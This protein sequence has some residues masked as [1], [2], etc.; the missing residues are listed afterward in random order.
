M[1]MTS[2]GSSGGFCAFNACWYRNDYFRRAYLASPTF[3]ALAGA[4]EFL[5]YAARCEPRPIRVY[6]TFDEFEPVVFSG[7]N[8]EVGLAAIRFLTSSGY[9]FRWQYYPGKGHTWGINDYDTQLNALGFIWKNWVTKPVAVLDYS[10]TLNAVIDKNSPWQ[11]VADQTLLPPR[12]AASVDRGTH[13]ARGGEIWLVPKSA[14][15]PKVAEGF[16]DISALTISSDLWRLYIA[17]KRQRYVLSMS[18][19]PDGS[20][21]DLRR[22]NVL[23]LAT[24]STVM[25]ARDMALDTRDRIYAATDAGIQV[26][27]PDTYVQMI[28]PLPGDLPADKVVFEGQTLYVTSGSRIFKR[29]LKVTGRTAGSP[30]SPPLVALELKMIT[31]PFLTGTNRQ[32]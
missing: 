20:L 23:L 7:N 8:Y 30:M 3:H 4:D 25:G 1:H 18:I 29:L 32:R 22:V 16:N 5:S 19:A 27:T 10:P 13:E 28:L 24:G 15:P 2:G 14:A 31:H 12:V 17:D 11:T 6:L 21:K 9:D 26:A